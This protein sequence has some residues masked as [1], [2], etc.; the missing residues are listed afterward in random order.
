MTIS[1]PA[2]F[3]AAAFL[4]F[5]A[6]G[7]VDSSTAQA[8]TFGSGDNTFEIE[9]VTIGDAGNAPDTTGSPNPAGAVAY[10]YRMGKYE[11]SEA[12]IDAANAIAAD[13]GDP[14]GITHDNRGPNKPATRVSWF[15]AAQFVNWLNTSK[16]STPAYK[17]DDQGVFQLWEPTDPG[18][19]SDN[20]FRNTK[21]Q[22]FLPSAD[23]WYKAA[24]YDPVTDQYFDFPNGSNTAPIPTAGGT[25]PGTAVY[26]LGGPADIMLG[27]GPSPFG[28][29]AQAGNVWEWDETAVDLVNDDP[30]EN[31]G[32]R[33]WAWGTIG[34][35][36]ELSSSFRHFIWT[37]SFS[38]GDVGFRIAS[39]PEP[40]TIW[41]MVVAA[42]GLLPRRRS[43]CRTAPQF[44]G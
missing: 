41:L 30:I 31:R 9:F 25:A 36:N 21:A 3:S 14:L 10:E 4:L 27:G 42:S 34:D 11:I 29:V 16:G 39:I 5:L 20:R 18:Y 22:Y 12:M 15:E 8:D 19:N 24:F 40:S 37:P 26:N 32:F 6:I 33:G 28:T 35:P 44:R 17:F 7:T 13:A 38:V 2:F 43:V 23:E 1:Q